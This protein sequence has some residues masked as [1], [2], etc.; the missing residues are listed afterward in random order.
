MRPSDATDEEIVA[1]GERLVSSG[2]PVTG[3]ALRM[4][5]GRGMAARLKAV[6]E[7]H[8]AA[9]AAQTTV[10]IVDLPAE[11][12]ERLAQLQK[13][14]GERLAALAAEINLTAV[15]SAERRVVEAIRAAEARGEQAQHELADA[16]AAMEALESR[17][18]VSEATNRDQAAKIATISTAHQAQA[19]ELAQL[20]ER[21]AHAEEGVERERAA[22]REERASHQA[23]A[24]RVR[25]ELATLHSAAQAERKKDQ[26]SAADA[27]EEVARLQ[28]KLEL[29]TAQYADL[30]RTLGERG[31]AGKRPGSPPPAAG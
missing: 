6:W 23:Q 27:R 31:A 3:Y 29:A 12:K 5:V 1:A 21:L 30:L 2:K 15:E 7:Q 19:V 18:E 24:E 4:A 16:A 14:F 10:A 22:A 26:A 9:K 13:E 28:G 25:D 20:R 8:I 17:L 11:V